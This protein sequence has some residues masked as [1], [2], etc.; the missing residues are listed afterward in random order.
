[1]ILSLGTG[2][3]TKS[4]PYDE[5]KDWGLAKWAKP[6]LDTIFDGVSDTVDYQLKHLLKN[7][8]YRMQV[9]LSH[10]GRDEMD[11]ASN[12]NIYE[13]KLLGQSIIDKWQKNGDLE[14]LCNKLV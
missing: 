8:Y 5:A 3:Q 12:E 14:R 11:N 13:L 1:M 10:L 4:I 9:S 2:G 7:N 6:I